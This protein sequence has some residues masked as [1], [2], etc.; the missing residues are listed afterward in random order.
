MRI[1]ILT[2]FPRMCETV[3]DESIIGTARAKGLVEIYCHNIRDYTTDKHR[4]ADDY[5]YGG[6][7]GM[8]L[9]AEPCARCFDAVAAA[10]GK[11]PYLVYMSPRGRVFDQKTAKEFSRM[12]N[13]CLLCGH[14]EGIDQRFID[15][16]VDMELSVGDYV[17]TGGELAALAVAD[18]VSRLLPGVLAEEAAFTDESHYSG[19]LE[20]P[21]YTRPAE[22]RGRAVPEVLLSG[23][24]K[25]I[26]AW[27]RSK[28]IETTARFRPDMLASADLTDA[29]RD[30]AK[31]FMDDQ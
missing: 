17:M 23:D 25:L 6:G 20:Y 26:G 15:E 12:D 8:L 28:A 30:A 11:R 27:K 7:Q 29:E 13:L 2:L 16:Y 3:L 21:Q 5:P 9:C 1:D 19:L 18:T 24:P 14:Y 10:A 22:W 4:R 31:A